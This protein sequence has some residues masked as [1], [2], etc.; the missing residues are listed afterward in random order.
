MLQTRGPTF[1]QCHGIIE[2][3]TVV[4]VVEFL[5]WKPSCIYQKGLLFRGGC[6]KGEGCYESDL[7]QIRRF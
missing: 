3:L 1:E 4:V 6:H 7:L 2:S 5:R